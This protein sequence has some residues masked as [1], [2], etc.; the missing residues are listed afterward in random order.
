MNRLRTIGY[1]S[2]STFLFV[3]LTFSNCYAGDE[4]VMNSFLGIKLGMTK[5]EVIKRLSELEIKDYKFYESSPNKETLRFLY[6]I[7][8]DE[9]ED[10][11]I[12]VLFEQDSVCEIQICFFSM[13]AGAHNYKARID[14]PFKKFLDEINKEYDNSINWKGKWRSKDKCV[15]L[16]TDRYNIEGKAYYALVIKDNTD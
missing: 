11:I 15:I 3:L 14:K 4:K 8:E 10:N 2:Y 12:R 7:Y 5:N 1:L 16:K 9:L 6:E 13:I